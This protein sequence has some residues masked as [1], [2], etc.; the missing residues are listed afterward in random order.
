MLSSTTHHTATVNGIQLHYVRAGQG[1]PVVL[2]HGYPET[3]YAWRKIMPTLAEYYTVIAPD[4][5]GFG[6]S[7]KPETGYDKRLLLKTF[8]NSYITS[9]MSK[10]F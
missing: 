2:I 6:D 1:D 4:M 9:V 8:T 7:A 10:S 5:R 3:W